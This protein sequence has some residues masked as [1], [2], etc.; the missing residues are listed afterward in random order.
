MFSYDDDYSN[1]TIASPKFLDDYPNN[2]NINSNNKKGP[3]KTIF[4]HFD[5]SKDCDAF[6]K[7]ITPRY[8]VLHTCCYSNTE[9]G[10]TGIGIDYLFEAQVGILYDK[11]KKDLEK[12]KLCKL[13]LKEKKSEND[14]CCVCLEN[15]EFRTFCKHVLCKECLQKGEKDFKLK[16]CPICRI[17]LKEF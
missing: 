15:C 4:Y 10:Y 13:R 9:K 8:K 17:E 11:F 14:V 2:L 5:H 7:L 16:L 3:Q 6:I 1:S 12:T